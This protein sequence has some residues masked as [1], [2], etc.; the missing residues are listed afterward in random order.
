MTDTKEKFA[1]TD[2]LN[3]QNNYNT[4]ISLNQAGIPDELKNIHQWVCW[5]IEYKKGKPTKVPVNPK[6]KGNAIPNNSSTWSS[7]EQALQTYNSNK[8]LLNG[9]GF[10]FTKDD[11]FVGVDLD[12]C[13]GEKGN[14][15]SWALDI[16]NTLNSYTEYSPSGKG[17]HII[18]KGD[19][20]GNKNRKNGIEI[21]KTG[22]YFTIT[23]ANFPNTPL[24]INHRQEELDKV[25]KDT[26]DTDNKETKRVNNKFS[27]NAKFESLFA[28]NWKGY[29]E[30][31]S[32]ADLALCSHLAYKNNG[33][34]NAVDNEFRS[35]GLMRDKWD[36]M[37]GSQTYGQTTIETALANYMQ[38]NHFTSNKD[39]FIFSEDRL[40][41][42]FANKHNKNWRYVAVW[43]KWFLWNGRCWNEENTFKII[44][45]A[46]KTCRN[47]PNA[48]EQQLRHI[49]SHKTI[50]NIVK[51]AQ[52]DR[53]IAFVSDGFDK[54]A[55][56]LNTPKGTIDL[57]TGDIRPHKKEDYITKITTASPAD[58]PTPVWNKFL[59]DITDGNKELQ[60]FLQR[61]LGYCLTGSTEEQILLF[62]Y[63]SGANGKSV[64]LN[65]ISEILGSYSKTAP[66]DTFTATK[67]NKHSTDIAGLK[68][69]RLVTAT[70]T[71]SGQCWAESKI[72]QLT[73]SDKV[74]ARFM[75]QD[76]FEYTPQYKIIIAGNHK[77]SIRNIDEAMRRRIV[78]VPFDKTI[79]PE[80]RD[81][82]L[83]EKLLLEAEGILMWI[84][85][86]CL[87]WQNEGL[88]VP[89]IIRNTTDEYFLEE[90]V[91]GGWLSECC[92]VGNNY[93][94]LSSELFDSYRNYCEENG[95]YIYSQ[96]K[97]IENLK[98]RGF[99]EWKHPQTRRN[100]LMGLKPL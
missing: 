74:S 86:G 65:V 78:L 1:Q 26:F 14:I 34:Y 84:L 3:S 11:D 29:Y 6:T 27:Q 98:S 31:Q 9:I 4:A 53:R 16:I 44:D 85:E 56:L 88:Q 61:V 28:G 32:E 45:E 57:K 52:T 55:W 47:I 15:E 100:G 49:E 99:K 43:N 13:I 33:D 46:R 50:T 60:S 59:D 90:D 19:K 73:G 76:N 66:M 69:A 87:K 51:L 24:A 21:Y 12:K 97:F 93:T 81:K 96:K 48:K 37:R 80:K 63:G 68:G 91:I 42:E 22:R 36:E 23:G 82:K 41:Q 5:K 67:G 2:E 20:I 72:K 64:F 30:S 8:N 71:E 39:D 40:A 38:N 95:E 94:G 77:P 17:F 89:Q 10:V 83:Q 58:M 35:S 54:Y 75:R 70:E 62:L 92:E 79:P 7:F 25:Y 18:V